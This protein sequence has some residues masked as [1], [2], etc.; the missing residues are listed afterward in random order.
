MQKYI[1]S[2]DDGGTYIKAALF[3]LQGRQIALAKRR[4]HALAPKD[5]FAEYDQ[6]ELWELN[7]A[8]MRE[9][10]EASGVDPAEIACIGISAQG[11]GFY[12]VDAQG[13]SIRNAIS[14]SDIRAQ[15]YVDR[16]TTDGT[17]QIT[18]PKMYR[19]VTAAQLNAILA[20]L[21]DNEPDNYARIHRLFAMKD[22]IIYRLTGKMVGGYGCFS[23][24]CLMNQNTME[25]DVELA[26]AFGIPEMIDKFG[27]MYWDTQVC[28]YVSE[29]AAKRC[30]CLAGTPVAAGSHDVVACA[31]ALGAIDSDYCFMIA[32]THGINGYVSS[33]PIT[34]GTIKYNEMFALP[35]KYLIEEA[36]PSSAASLEWLIHV[37]NGEGEGAAKLSYDE[38]NRMVESVDPEDD[39]PIF[40][41]YLQ[42]NRNNAYACAGWNGLKRSH[43]RAHMLRTVF[44]GVAFAHKMQCEYLFKNRDL[45]KCIRFAGGAANSPVWS[46]IFADVIGID[47]E[48]VPKQETSAKGAAIIAATACGAFASLEQ[49]IEAMVSPCEKVHPRMQYSDAY[50]KR[51][52]IFKKLTEQED[53]I[54]KGGQTL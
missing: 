28:G 19:L 3:D 41:P 2:I 23:A 7:C 43:T 10:I 50:E 20:W 15:S 33:K 29:E 26:E 48:V 14:S 51:Y 38:I 36:Y 52:A 31:T 49:A 9:A 24:S 5:G 42:G 32:G 47:V 1:L 45:P 46:Q 40:L 8:C 18:Y 16:W 34:D 27:P 53:E 25:M 39:V 37:L 12:A 11:C 21:K 17:N 13:K 6:D 4:N 30:G 54:Y 35:G 22:L 44:E